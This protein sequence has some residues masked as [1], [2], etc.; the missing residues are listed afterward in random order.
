MTLYAENQPILEINDLKPCPFCGGE[1]TNIF[2]Q[3]NNAMFVG[4]KFCGTRKGVVIRD[5]ENNGSCT[6]EKLTEAYEEAA[7]LWNERY[8]P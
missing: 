6:I 7:R 3:L 8:E 5:L 4:C 1:A 2:K